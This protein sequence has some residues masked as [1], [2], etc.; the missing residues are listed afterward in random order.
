VVHIIIN[1]ILLI[2]III[3][4]I[5]CLAGTAR[6]YRV[7]KNGIKKLSVLIDSEHV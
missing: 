7:N 3:K 1:I 5:Y 4:V 6:N 2:N